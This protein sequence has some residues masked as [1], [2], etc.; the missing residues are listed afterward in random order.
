MHRKSNFSKEQV[1]TG[2]N[3][4]QPEC[5]LGVLVDC[6]LTWRTQVCYQAACANKLLGYI[7]RNARYI[8]GTSIRHTLYLGLVHV[9]FAYVTHVWAPQ[10]IELISKLQKSQ[11]CTTKFILHLP[12]ITEIFY[13]ERLMSLDLHC[14]SCMLLA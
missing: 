6:D 5:D 2:I 7:R 11:R 3:I 12:F 4:L 8:Q 13:K 14:T 10:A 1:S 9:H